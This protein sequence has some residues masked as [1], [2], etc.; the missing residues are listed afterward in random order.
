MVRLKGL[1]E[2]PAWI[3]HLGCHLGC[4]D[5]LGLDISPAWV[6][7]G[8]GHA[9]VI[10]VHEVLCHSGPT[11][12]RTDAVDHLAGNLGYMVDGVTGHKSQR[13]FEAKQKIAWALATGCIDTGVPCYGWELHIPEW[14][15]ITGYDDVGYYYSGPG[16]D[17]CRMPLPWEKLADT[18][19]GWLSMHCVLPC[20]PVE[21]AEAVREALTFALDHAQGEYAHEGYAAGP[22][23]FELWAEALETG[24]ADRFGAGYN[25]ACWLECRE[26]AVRFLQE[27]KGRLAG[28]A[29]AAFAEAIEHYTT[30]HDRLKAAVE[31][32]PFQSPS[33]E[34]EGER[35]QDPEAAA[36]L[37]EVG[38][39]EERGLEA[40]RRIR[41]AL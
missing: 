37:R 6:Y 8:T 40:L 16:A 21:D 32:V 28:R 1:Q 27:A 18:G 17:E 38:A 3:T 9:F 19:I 33:D 31:R 41:E 34:V 29:H 2:K 26:M 14:Y 11:A 5:Y 12:W 24:R 23:A 39:A 25:G 10:N 4:I 30:V 20:E 36:L 15:V 7:G 22:A 13:E 35:V